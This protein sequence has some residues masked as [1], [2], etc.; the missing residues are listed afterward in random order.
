MDELKLQRLVFIS[1]GKRHDRLFSLC[2]AFRARPYTPPSTTVALLR[3]FGP[4]Q[5]HGRM[6]KRT[7]SND[8]VLACIFVSSLLYWGSG[9]EEEPP[10][11]HGHREPCIPLHP[12]TLVCLPYLTS[13]QPQLARISS[14]PVRP[15]IKAPNRAALHGRIPPRTVSPGK[16]RN[17][18]VANV[19]MFAL[20]DTQSL[21][22]TKSQTLAAAVG[23]NASGS[24]AKCS[25]G[26]GFGEHR[27][28]TASV[29]FGDPSC[30]S[31]PINTNLRFDRI[32]LSTKTVEKGNPSLCLVSLKRMY[33]PARKR[34]PTAF[35]LSS[36]WVAFLLPAANGSSSSGTAHCTA[37]HLQVGTRT[38]E[39]TKQKTAPKRV[40]RI[41]FRT[42]RRQALAA[43]IV[44]L[45]AV[46]PRGEAG[47]ICFN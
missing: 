19:W 21:S 47:H 38:R 5:A 25:S 44:G 37:L 45:A 27:S 11:S 24:S 8:R 42:A 12:T 3:Y 1:H 26:M 6:A 22:P 31:K 46:V 4:E 9:G 36:E 28:T 40:H 15:L 20:T 16:R 30:K 10:W 32:A 7:K 39:E 43:P 13:Q 33:F 18:S 17:M 29:R 41:C 34:Q 35:I 23:Q 2:I 14:R